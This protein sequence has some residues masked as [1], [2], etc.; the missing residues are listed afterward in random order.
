MAELAENYLESNEN[1]EKKNKNDDKIDLL[2]VEITN[3]NIA[4]NVLIGFI[5]LAQSRGCYALNESSK[6][7]EAIKIFQNNELY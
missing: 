2:Q 4:L 5:G 6:I 3:E 1:T 7:F